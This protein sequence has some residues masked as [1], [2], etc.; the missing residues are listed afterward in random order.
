MRIRDIRREPGAPGKARWAATFDWE[1]NDRA[2]FEMRFEEDRD[3]AE[4]SRGE[5][6][7]F[8]LASI[9]PAWRRGERRI[10]V[11]GRI[12]P[13]LRD[14]LD[15]AQQILSS[16][17]GPDRVPVALEPSEGFHSQ[18]RAGKAALFLTG[19]VDSLHMLRVNRS[20]FPAGHPASFQEAIYVSR[21]S[22]VEESP[23]E[24]SLD[25]AQRQ[26]RAVESICSENGL[27]F[28]CIESNFRLLDHGDWMV[29]P[30]DQGALLAAAAHVL[31]GRI[32]TASLAASHDL[33]LLP[34]WGTHPLLDPQYS[35]SGLE[36]R[37][38]GIAH[39]RFK[40]L[41]EIADWE[42]ARRRLVVCFEGPMPAGQLNC[43][44][45][46][47]CLRTMTGLLVLGALDRFPVFGSTGV[48]EEK[49]LEMN[50]GYHSEFFRWL[51]TPLVEPLRRLGRAD[52]ARAVKE[53]LRSARRHRAWIE[54]TDWRG[55]IRRFDRKHFGGRLCSA[56]RRLRRLPAAENPDSPDRR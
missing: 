41:R 29:A 12:C 22:F 26:A 23:S 3:S 37:H 13:R 56:S 11:E 54:E 7:P 21:L 32:A 6:H 35:S 48:T 27:R 8:L 46:E 42:T 20:A 43:G 10:A 1:E 28:R 18:D 9:L 31:A 49:L 5:V 34:A 38:E 44:E 17:Y 40:K 47:K 33:D 51:W 24:R 25:L 16:W 4:H 55:R 2:P 14:G 52:L 19:G 36:F 30:Q 45:C 53:K 50:F 15:A 39:P